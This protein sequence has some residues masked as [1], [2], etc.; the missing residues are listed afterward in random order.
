MTDDTI[1]SYLLFA[2]QPENKFVEG[3]KSLLQSHW[4][5]PESEGSYEYFVDERRLKTQSLDELFTH[6]H[7]AHSAGITVEKDDFE[8]GLMTDAQGYPFEDVSNIEVWSWSWE[9]D[10]G[11]NEPGRP[12]ATKNVERYVSAITLLSTILDPVYAYGKRMETVDPDTVPDEE[13]LTNHVVN[14]IFWLNIFSEPLVEKFGRDRI[15]SAPAWR[16]DEL[17]TGTIV[18]IAED[19]PVRPS[20]EW[21]GSRSKIADHLGM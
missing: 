18:L 11:V 21:Q 20:K 1:S 15:L 3:I 10:Y 16:V 2:E 14:E 7:Q 5:I 9:F 19:S 12:F 8:I 17:D 6:L 4:N 13:G